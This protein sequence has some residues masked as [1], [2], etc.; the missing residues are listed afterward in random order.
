VEPPYDQRVIEEVLIEAEAPPGQKQA[1]DEMF[2]RA[3]F[4]VQSRAALHRRSAGD[5]PW[6]VY[7]TLAVPIASFFAAFGSEA[8]KDAHAAV[9]A[10]AKAMY[11]ARKE[12]GLGQGHISL[13][14]PSNELVLA[15]EWPDEA[16]DALAEID[17]AQVEGGYLVWYEGRWIDPLSQRPE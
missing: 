3:G 8:G 6:I 5:L 9:K 13:V 17:W 10:W 4:D 14:D 11:E 15:S 1:V 7:V 16:L 12:S 2:A